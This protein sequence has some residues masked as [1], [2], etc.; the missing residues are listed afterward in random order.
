MDVRYKEKSSFKDGYTFQKTIS[1]SMRIYLD[2]LP[3]WVTLPHSSSSLFGS[4][5]L[6]VIQWPVVVLFFAAS[7]ENVRV[8]N[9]VLGRFETSVLKWRLSWFKTVGSAI[10][11][12]FA[13]AIRGSFAPWWFQ[14][15]HRCILHSIV[16]P[17]VLSS[18]NLIAQSTDNRPLF[19]FLQ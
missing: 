19:W 3:M 14:F 6:Q 9:Q 2:G 15:R 7:P 13:L 5:L 11:S 17:F 10:D 1:V 12:L 4:K 16:R 8:V 18:L